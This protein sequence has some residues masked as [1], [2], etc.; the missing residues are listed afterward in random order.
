MLIEHLATLAL[1][2]LLLAAAAIDVRTM[3]IPNALNAAIAVAGLVVTWYLGR[4]LVAA[5]VGIVLGYGVLAAANL[6]YRHARGRDGIGMGDAKLLGA[7]GAWIGWSG[8]PFVI[9]FASATGLVFVAVLRLIGRQ[10]SS[11]DA[12]P[13]GPWLCF[14]ILTVWLVQTYATLL[15]R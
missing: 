7:A 2:A 5:F 10:L 3:R 12:M 6:A 8:L 11:S 15:L 14:G 1:A 4:D 13:F 9:L